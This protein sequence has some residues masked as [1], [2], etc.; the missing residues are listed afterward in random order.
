MS[1]AAY[2][3]ICYQ[4]V[5]N[6]LR[7]GA[8]WCP[9]HGRVFVEYQRPKSQETVHDSDGNE[10][11]RG[12]TVTDGEGGTGYVLRVTDLDVDGPMD[13]GDPPLVVPPT[14]VVEYRDGST[15]EFTTYSTATG[16]HDEE[17]APWVCDDLLVSP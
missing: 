17:T 3:P 6:L 11:R 8:G 2:C 14:I 15:L 1:T 9:D 13:Y 10:V 4:A 5:T 7:D 12:M 16:M